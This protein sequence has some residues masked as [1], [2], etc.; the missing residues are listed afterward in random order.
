M[1]QQPKK[2]KKKR[3]KSERQNSENV[4]FEF[5]PPEKDTKHSRIIC[6]SNHYTT[7]AELLGRELF[8]VDKLS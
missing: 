6:A 4:W 5:A 1:K 7:E 8:F 2:K 3:K